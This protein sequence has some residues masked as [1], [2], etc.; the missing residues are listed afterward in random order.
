MHAEWSAREQTHEQRAECSVRSSALCQRQSRRQTAASH[1]CV[2][3][4]SAP[5]L[6][7]DTDWPQRISSLMCT[8]KKRLITAVFGPMKTA[9]VSLV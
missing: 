9:G 7:V 4:R 6:C 5:I 8:P 3:Q 1:P 2:R